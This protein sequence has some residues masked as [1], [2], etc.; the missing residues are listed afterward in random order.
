MS[1]FATNYQNVLHLNQYT[2]GRLWSQNV[3]PFEGAGALAIVLKSIK[4]ALVKCVHFKLGLNKW[5][6]LSVLTNKNFSDWTSGLYVENCTFA[7]IC[8]YEVFLALVWEITPEVCPRIFKYTL[9][10][11]LPSSWLH[12][13]SMISNTFII[14]LM[15]TTLKNVELLK[16]IKIMEAA[17][18]CFGLQWNHHQGDTAST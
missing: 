14:Q 10:I 6:V 7:D 15:H 18:T 16:H 5:G 9:N 13:A 17:P 8:V 11:I 12:R 4:N 2:H 3:A 1:H